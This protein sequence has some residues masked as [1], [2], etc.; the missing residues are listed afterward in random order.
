MIF[1]LLVAPVV[2]TNLFSEG[3]NLHPA[4]HQVVRQAD[5][6]KVQRLLKAF[7][8]AAVSL[9]G[10]SKAGGMT[11][12]HND[13]SSVVLQGGFHHFSGMNLR[14]VY[15]A[16]EQRFVGYQAVLIIQK[17]RDKLFTLL[18]GQMQTQPVADGM[19]GGK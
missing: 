17:E 10:F 1:I 19:A 7:C 13:G 9:T 15:G 12:G 18:C 5:I 6:H 4:H 14:M 2:I 16:A 3:D 8:H 11:V